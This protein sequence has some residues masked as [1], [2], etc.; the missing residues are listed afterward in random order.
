MESF[1]YTVDVAE[2]HKWV[3][4]RSITALREEWECVVLDVYHLPSSLEPTNT[5]GFNHHGIALVET[6]G[7]PKK[8]VI[9]PIACHMN[10]ELT[11]KADSILSTFLVQFRKETQVC[12][13]WQF[14][15]VNIRTTAAFIDPKLYDKV[16]YEYF[17]LDPT[18]LEYLERVAFRNSLIEA[19]IKLIQPLCT[20]RE[21]VNRFYAEELSR[22]LIRKI[23]ETNSKKIRVHKPPESSLTCQQKRRLND[24]LTCQVQAGLSVS[25]SEAA[26]YV[27]LSIELMLKRYYSEFNTPVSTAERSLRLSSVQYYLRYTNKSVKEIALFLGFQSANSLTK[28]FSYNAGVSPMNYRK[29]FRRC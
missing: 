1:Q 17:G 28:F 11:F 26:E 24:Y 13:E 23:I 20:S 14:P 9:G 4:G 7:C 12:W 2:Y 18:G 16:A 8:R 10:K 21:L 3:P 29:E 22:Y 5:P 15:G 6:P 25:I 27:G 19:V